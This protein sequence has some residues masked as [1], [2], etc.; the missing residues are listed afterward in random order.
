MA[1]KHL[2]GMYILI[3]FSCL[4]L[5]VIFQQI[6]RIETD[7]DP[8]SRAVT[9]AALLSS[10]ASRE[11]FEPQHVTELDPDSSFLIITDENG[12]T[13]TSTAKLNDKLLQIPKGV[14]SYTKDHGLHHVTWSPSKDIRQA[15]TITPFKNDKTG[16][17][18][19]VAAGVGLHETEQ[20][21]NRVGLLIAF[22]WTG[23]IVI[24][25]LF[26]KP[27]KKSLQSAD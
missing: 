2:I 3:T 21:I 22:S 15:T 25:T 10:G 14:F 7:D 26:F 5:Y 13:R 24:T 9:T 17:R 11:L 18:G 19:Y 20:L 1:H 8:S 12:E 27:H 23:L 6:L 16:E 4:S